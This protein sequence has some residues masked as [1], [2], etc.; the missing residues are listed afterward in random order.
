[1]GSARAAWGEE[2]GIKVRCITD[3]EQLDVR[4]KRPSG[5]KGMVTPATDNAL[6]RETICKW[7]VMTLI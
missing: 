5:T 4:R 1:M 6:Q 7:K 3:L 2:R